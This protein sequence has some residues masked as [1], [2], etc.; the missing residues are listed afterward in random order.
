MDKL[1]E[2]ADA[3]RIH[4]EALVSDLDLAV[5][6][7]PDALPTNGTSR[8]DLQAARDAAMVARDAARDALTHLT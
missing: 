1:A 6:T 5:R 8:A 4:C 3:I 2:H 7:T